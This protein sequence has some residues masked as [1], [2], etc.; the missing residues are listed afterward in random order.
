M[1]IYVD[2]D[3][4]I[5]DSEKLLFEE[6]KK[7]KNQNEILKIKYIQEKDW[8]ELLSK[9]NVINNGIEILKSLRKDI[10]IL[11]KVFSMENEGV[12]KIKILR[13]M[14]IYNDVIL[15]PGH[16]KKTDVVSAKGNVL[17][18]DTVHNLDDWILAGGLPIYF[19]KDNS[20]IDGWNNKNKV[21][22]MTNSLE[23][24]RKL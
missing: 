18:D 11:T 23:I 1:K 14:G 7:F 22:R 16:L 5:F 10:S 19:N 4:V 2:F 15:S 20:N 21:Y 6:Y 3:G 24:I 8:E 17:I 9:C 12:A 13:S